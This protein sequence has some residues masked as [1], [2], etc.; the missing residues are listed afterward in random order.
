MFNSKIFTKYPVIT[1][2]ADM[3][4]FE[5]LGRQSLAPLLESLV[6]WLHE[7]AKQDGVTQLL[8]LARDGY[9]MQRAYQ[10]VIPA[11]QQ[12]P[13]QYMYASRRLFNLAAIRQLDEA[14]MHFLIG[15][16]V[17]M[18]VGRYLERA[19]LDPQECK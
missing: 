7:Q 15:D 5:L 14:A 19:G 4:V 16:N 17:V 10:A 6:L 2:E 18:P 13:N 1:Q 8:F 12:I 9:M 11:S 3:A